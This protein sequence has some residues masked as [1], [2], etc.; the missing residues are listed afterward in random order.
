MTS[1]LV[2]EEVP[3]EV[4][5]TKA[6]KGFTLLEVVIALTVFAFLIGGLL[7]FLPWG[8]E[9]VGQ[10]KDQSIAYGLVD[11]T[12]VEL[13]RMGFSLVEAGTNRLQET[14]NSTLDPRRAPAVYQVLLVATA[15]GD[16]ISFEHV[17]KQEEQDY[18]DS[19]QREEG[20]VI[21]QFD[22][23][24]G[25]IVN[26][27]RTA[28]DLPVSLTGFTEEDQAT[29]PHSTRWIPEEERYFLIKC[30]QFGWDDEDPSIPHRH[31][32]HPSNGFLALQV[33]VQWPYKIP[34]PSQGE[35]GFRR[36]AEK[37]RK[38]F[39]FPLAIVR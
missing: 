16:L 38:H 15:Q 17:V 4:V 33:D 10:V 14:Y 8:V 7:G 29:F 1:E 19:T 30:T 36:V 5:V 23:D 39:R 27:N 22:K 21:E 6:K 12:Q 2:E 11:G 35:N 13:E 24:L 25:G 31:Q 34:D 18:L 9:G 32:H 26:F 28:D 3:V 37:Y 20:E